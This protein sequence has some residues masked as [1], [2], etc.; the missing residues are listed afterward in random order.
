MRHRIAALEAELS[1]VNQRLPSG[2]NWYGKAE[3]RFRT[4]NLEQAAV[5][6]AHG[7][8]EGAFLRVN[9]KLCDMLGHRKV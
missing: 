5:G 3:M 7:S 4:N 6:M 1:K 2:A 8:P 9:Q